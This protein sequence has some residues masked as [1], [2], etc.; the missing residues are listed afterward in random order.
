VASFNGQRLVIT[1]TVVTASDRTIDGTTVAKTVK[2][3]WLTRPGVTGWNVQRQY[4][5]QLLP[6]PAMTFPAATLT[7]EDQ[8]AAPGYIYIYWV[9]GCTAD[10]KNCS[11]PSSDGGYHSNYP[12]VTD[13][14]ATDG[15]FRTPEVTPRP[16][17]NVTFTTLNNPWVMRYLLNRSDDAAGLVNV[18]T[19]DLGFWQTGAAVSY[20][21]TTANIGQTYYYWVE[22]CDFV[23]GLYWCGD[24]ST[25][26]SGWSP[27]PTPTGLT[28]TNSTAG[29]HGTW[30][31]VAISGITYRGFRSTTSAFANFPNGGQLLTST[32][33]TDPTG[34]AGVNYWYFIKACLGDKCSE[35]TAGAMGGKLVP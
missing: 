9:W 18:L 30:D 22:A 27:I 15:T 5:G 32:E 12:A 26:N 20:W 21:D 14:N 33:G 13:L 23:G 17:V 10:G 4:G 16:A 31:P 6:S 34:V 3:D 25:I 35:A 19:T 11:A 24:N 29:V 7:G 1:P 28:I 8:W 2:V